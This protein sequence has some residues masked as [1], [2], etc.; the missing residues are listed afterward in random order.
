MK[1][2]L[3]VT[4]F[5]IFGSVCCFGQKVLT[6]D[7]TQIKARIEN[8][9]ASFYYPALMQRFVKGDTTFTDDECAAIYYGSYFQ[10]VFD[11][12]ATI[13]EAFTKL[14]DA[15][16][17]GKA[18]FIGL[19]ELNKNPVNAALTFK[20]LVCYD[21]LD[22]KD[23][24]TM[25]ANRYFTMLKA[26]YNSGEGSDIERAMVVLKVADEYEILKDAHLSS[27]YQT[28]MGSTDKLVLDDASK[29]KAKIE[30]LYFNVEIPLHYLNEKLKSTTKNNSK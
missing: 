5:V 19:N 29:K 18:L 13:S 7:F 28:L 23:S 8:E 27:A 3:F 11:P 25:Y 14:Y 12:Y 2:Q 20:I 4:L 17:Y 10:P 15:K 30:A 26:I 21:A 24:A 1:K 9:N 22:L 16:L 6:V